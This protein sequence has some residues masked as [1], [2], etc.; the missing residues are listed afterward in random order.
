MCCALR[1]LSLLLLFTSTTLSLAVA[2]QRRVWFAGASFGPVVQ[3]RQGNEF[4]RQSGL[5][6]NARAGY[7]FGSFL[8]AQIALSHTSVN[9]K[10]EVADAVP[11]GL[12]ARIPCPAADPLPCGPDP[13]VGPVK[14]V[15]AGAG[16]EASAGGR[17]ARVFA[18]LTPGV[19]WVYER[20]PEAQGAS[21]G[22]GLGG[23]GSVR[24]LDPLWLVLDLQYHQIFSRGASPRWLLPIGLGVQVRE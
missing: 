18:S 5:V 13:F 11:G 21:A 24:L 20:A 16:L 8:S 6:V 10:Y 9:G 19:Y 23:G 4:L 7:R 15:I 3:D 17:T 12:L 14:A 1:L 2:Q 22:L